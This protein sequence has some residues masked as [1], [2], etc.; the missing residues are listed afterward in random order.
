MRPDTVAVFEGA[1][2]Q[3]AT[4][5]KPL[6]LTANADGSDKRK[7]LFIHRPKAP[8]VFRD[9]KINANNLP[10]T[11]R[12]NKKALLLSDLRYEYLKAFNQDIKTGCAIIR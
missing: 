12:R 9:A 11:D 1:I 4:K 3:G 7:L 5:D 8:R 6:P 10:V 2:P